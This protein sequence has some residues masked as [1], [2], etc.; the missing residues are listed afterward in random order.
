MSCADFLIHVG[1]IPQKFDQLTDLFEIHGPKDLHTNHIDQMPYLFA[2]V[3]S[4]S[5]D[6]LVIFDDKIVDVPKCVK[7]PYVFV[8]LQD[9]DL[10]LQNDE[11]SIT[12]LAIVAHV[13]TLLEYFV[14]EDL[15]H[16]HVLF[17]RVLRPRNG[18]L[19]ARE[20][21]FLDQMLAMALLEELDVV[22]H[23]IVHF[24]IVVFCPLIVRLRKDS[25]YRLSRMLVQSGA[26]RV[27]QSV[28][29]RHLVEQSEG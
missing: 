1:Q 22:D 18:T 15:I 21:S 23:E 20:P 29:R 6:F 2:L 8:G 12:Y 11:E 7:F 13:V 3:V 14:H 24:L 5:P 9:R 26:S 28:L 27:R 25:G 10:T 4:V 16:L 19:L 17:V